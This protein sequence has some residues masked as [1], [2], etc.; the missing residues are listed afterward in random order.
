MVL[1]DDVGLKDTYRLALCGLVV[2][3]AYSFLA[4]SPVSDWV[5]KFWTPLLG[6]TPE[7]VFL[8]KGWNGF[9]CHSPDD[10]SLLLNQFWVLGKSSLTLKRWRIAVNP[11]TEHF[12]H[13]HLW[14]LLPGL[15]LH[16]WNEGA[17]KAIGNALGQFISLDSSSFTSPSR[18]FGRVL[19][20]IDIHEGLP[21]LLDIDWRGRHH[22]QRL[23]Y[24]GIPFR[25]S[26]C[27][28][29]G[30]LRRDCRGK[31]TE[32]KLED[33]LLQEDPP[34]YMM[35]VDSE[36]DV[37]TLSPAR[38]GPPLETL[39]TLSSKLHLFFPSLFSSLTSWENLT[40]D[41]S[42]CLSRPSSRDPLLDRGGTDPSPTA[43][44]K[45]PIA[46]DVSKPTVPEPGHISRLLFLLLIPLALWCLLEL[47]TP[48]RGR[49]LLTFPLWFPH[50]SL[51]LFRTSRVSRF[52]PPLPL[53]SRTLRLL[54]YPALGNQRRRL[55]I[56]VLNLTPWYPMVGRLKKPR[57]FLLTWE[58]EVLSPWALWRQQVRRTSRAVKGKVMPGRGALL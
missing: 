50:Y 9:I 27:H 46:Q 22:K 3:L 1:G 56:S 21:E 20:E 16:L 41:N 36:A 19:V 29:T 12:Q 55:L 30:H 51:T 42:D 33:T 6:Y 53:R 8:T 48:L 24:Q 52:L 47:L 34:D 5:I 17:F 4:D 54:F 40:L 15:P 37:P 28:C 43:K 58:R 7:I 26:W 32:D 49:S 23:D 10:V 11:E 18:K 38:T 45:N 13:R 14:V 57:Y 2:R 39:D 31:L 44:C 35:E 25:C